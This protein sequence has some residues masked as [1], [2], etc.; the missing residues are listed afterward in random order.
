MANLNKNRMMTHR[1][2]DHMDS[3]SKEGVYAGSFEDCQEFIAEQGLAFGL[4]I[5]RI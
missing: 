2:I 4:E 1:V 5:I 3:I